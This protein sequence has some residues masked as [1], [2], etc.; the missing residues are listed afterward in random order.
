LRIRKI[1]FTENAVALAAF[2]AAVQL[3][4]GSRRI[5]LEDQLE[6]DPLNSG[7][8]WLLWELVHAQRSW[9]SAARSL[10]C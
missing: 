8:P 1:A 7:S 5:D 9:Q 4:V 6:G 3:L 10:L 2:A